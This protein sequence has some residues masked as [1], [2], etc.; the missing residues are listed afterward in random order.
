M[1]TD[2]ILSLQRKKKTQK[3]GQGDK[4]PKPAQYHTSSKSPPPKDSVTSLKQHHKEGNECS[5][6]RAWGHISF[7]LQQKLRTNKL[8]HK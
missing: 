4:L 2:H 5:N 3:G 7:K 8:I 1:L 6:T